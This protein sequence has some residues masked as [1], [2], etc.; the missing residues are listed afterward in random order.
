M[1]NCINDMMWLFNC[2]RQKVIVA[3]VVVSSLSS[4]SSIAAINRSANFIIVQNE[5]L[6]NNGQ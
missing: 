1:I 2:D 5:V 4:S 3:A 6:A